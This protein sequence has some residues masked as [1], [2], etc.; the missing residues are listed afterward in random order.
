MVEL[1]G[2]AARAGWAVFRR[3][4]WWGQL[5]G[6]LVAVS[7]VL[8]PFQGGDPPKKTE[9]L[10]EAGSVEDRLPRASTT[11]PPATI[12][13]TTTSTSTT[14]TSTTTTAP[15]PPPTTAAPQ[16]V[17][18]PPPTAAPVKRNC[19]PSYPDVCI[20]P[21]PPDL[22]CG[23]ISHRRFRVVGSDPHGFDRD[24]DGIGCESD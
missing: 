15:P 6:G 8:A 11:R 1:A 19:D 4:P 17:A 13:E 2:R 14:T 9:D 23:E 22:D 12:R 10:A 20:P 16:R 21:P 3:W 18:T 5:V 24:G 7:L